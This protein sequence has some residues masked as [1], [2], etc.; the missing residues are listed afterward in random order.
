MKRQMV[1]GQER[2]IWDP[3]LSLTPKEF[4]LGDPEIARIKSA[5]QTWDG[6]GVDADR[7]WLQPILE[8]LF[9]G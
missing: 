2:V 1:A 8:I 4:D 6:Y 3:A 9:V 7:Y 5:I